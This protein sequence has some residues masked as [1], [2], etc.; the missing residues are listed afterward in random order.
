MQNFPSSQKLLFRIEKRQVPPLSGRHRWETTRKRDSNGNAEA[1]S[2]AMNSPVATQGA[3]CPTIHDTATL[4]STVLA[5]IFPS[6]SKPLISLF[7]RKND[8]KTEEYIKND[9][10]MKEL[11]EKGLP[12]LEGD[13]V[14][15]YQRLTNWFMDELDKACDDL[16]KRLSD[17]N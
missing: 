14:E 2:I 15:E 12:F 9:N 6:G 7:P 4:L 5:K 8:M 10:R 11:M 17:D 16:E 3:I 1:R 13:E